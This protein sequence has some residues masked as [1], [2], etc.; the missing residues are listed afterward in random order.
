MRK[1]QIKEKA[2]SDHSDEEDISTDKKKQKNRIR[3]Q[4][5]EFHRKL[6]EVNLRIIQIGGDG[7]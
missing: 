1:R 5:D 3:E 6:E 4:E 2:D 7:N